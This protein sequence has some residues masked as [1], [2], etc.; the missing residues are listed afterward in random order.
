[1][2][3]T[4][5]APTVRIG[6]T[7]IAFLLAVYGFDAAYH[8]LHG[9]AAALQANAFR[10]LQLV[11]GQFPA[12]LQDAPLPLSLQ[13]ARWAL[14]LLTFWTTIAL[15]WQ[16]VRNPVRLRWIARR[17]EH[18]VIAGEEALAGRAAMAER[19]TERPTMLWVDDEQA[20]WIERLADRGVPHVPITGVDCGVDRLGLDR[21]RAVLLLADD[22]T[23][24]MALAAA[25]IENARATR[26]AGDPL[27]VIARIDD[28]DLRRSVEERH[29]RDGDRRTARLRVISLPDVAAR[30]LFLDHPLDRFRYLGDDGRL[31]LMLGFTPTIER[32]ALRLLAGS[33]HRDGRRPRVVV[34]DPD[35]A[36]K[37]AIFAAR[38]P[39]ADA[40]SPLLF[41]RATIDQPALLPRRLDDVAARHGHPV[42]IVIDCGDDARS[43]A[44]AYAVDGWFVAADRPTPPIHA[45]TSPCA[46]QQLASSIFPFG[47]AVA[48]ADPERLVQD[49]HDVLARAIHDHYFEGRLDEGEIVGTR[50]SLQEW[51]DLAE[52]IRDDNRLVADCYRLK[53]RDI[54]AQLGPRSDTGFRLD[55]TEIEELSR[56][57]HDRWMA[58]KLIDGWRHAPVRDDG[59]R[60]HPDIVP[61]D[62]LSERIRDLD[63][64]QIR[65]MTRLLSTTGQ[66]PRRILSVAIRASAAAGTVSVVDALVALATRYPDRAP[67]LVG[68]PDVPGVRDALAAA[69]AAG[70]PVRLVLDGHADRDAFRSLVRHA[71]TLFACPAGWSDA[72]TE[73][74]LVTH[75]DL[76][77]A[78]GPDGSVSAPWLD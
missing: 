74:W 63:R 14:P 23:R 19:M 11:V 30:S 44:L 10:A 68:R 43:L 29:A 56:A 48:L 45:R 27:P 16:Q 53:L 25:V 59:L 76:T 22:P 24:N 51:E 77:L 49:R 33:H 65:L 20:P 3:G 55:E 46:E 42:A 32:Y 61:Y 41:E 62:A 1:M 58:A 66:A 39:G 78:V 71:D 8:D 17:G 67:V 34:L 52:T 70:V 64:E 7:A 21:A 13:V 18:L 57:E 69:M 4:P 54:G 31:V 50:A 37:Q 12:D 35:A 38:R 2:T 75:S 72:D 47:S 28:L 60:H 9:H 15:G 6:A 40:L 5:S 26:T 73:A 36:A